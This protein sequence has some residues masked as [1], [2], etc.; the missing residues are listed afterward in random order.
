MRYFEIK[1]TRIPRRRI[2]QR[3][4]F[5]EKPHFRCKNGFFEQIAHQF[6]AKMPNFSH[7]FMKFRVT[8]QINIFTHWVNRNHRMGEWDTMLKF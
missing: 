3:E 7:V 2:G 6:E 4:T 8:H 5:E 1:I